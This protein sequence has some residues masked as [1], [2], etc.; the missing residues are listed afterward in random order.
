MVD[1][2]TKIGIIYKEI[3]VLCQ[4]DEI[5][6]NNFTLLVKNLHQ[7]AEYYR[8]FKE[9]RETSLIPRKIKY[10][11]SI[12]E[13]F[14]KLSEILALLKLYSNIGLEFLE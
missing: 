3:T 2:N 7:T 6:R 14:E 10:S 11:T 13:K 5:F 1:Y 4:N 12:K 8:N 9:I